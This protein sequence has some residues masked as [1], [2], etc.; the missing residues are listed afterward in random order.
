LNEGEFPLTPRPDPLL[1]DR[2]RA[3]LGSA[4]S[5]L[6]HDTT[7][8]LLDERFLG[9]VALT[10]ASQTLVL[11]RSLADGKGRRREPSSLW[12]AIDQ[13]IPDLPPT[14]LLPEG[15]RRPEHIATYSQLITNLLRRAVR[16]AAESADDATNRRLYD[17][18]ARAGG[19]DDARAR[20]LK[21]LAQS[22][23]RSLAYTNEATLPADV[24]ARLFAPPLE[25]TA[26]Q[27]EDF[28]ACP[29]KHFASRGLRLVDRANDDVTGADLSVACHEI[30]SQ[31][32]RELLKSRADWTNLQSSIDQGSFD[33]IVAAVGEDI[34]GQ[35]LLSS[36][37]NRYLLQRVRQTVSQVL[38]T[39]EAVAQ[40]A[41]FRTS[42]T[43]VRF[44]SGQAMPALQLNSP[45]GNQA[46]LRGKIDRIDS[47]ADRGAF[48]VLDY[49][50]TGS[51]LALDAVH[52]G[53]TIELL[54]QAAVVRRSGAFPPDSRPAGAFYT[55][56]LRKIEDISHPSEA[57]DPS[58]PQ[59]AL[60]TK[61][62]GL[63]DST[64]L[65]Q[66]DVQL[67]QGWSSV[68]SA[69]IKQ[70][71][72]LGFPGKSD[73]LDPGQFEAILGWVERRAGE[74]VDQIVAGDIS[75]SPYRLNQVSPCVRC[76]F[77]SVCRF[78]SSV[79]RYRHLSQVDRGAWLGAIGQPAAPVDLEVKTRSVRKKGTDNAR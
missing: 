8:M 51:T 1:P 41:E 34:R 71:G 6:A 61:A 65:P 66:Y 55:P 78:E 18:V 62:R 63:F 69:F 13:L 79:N 46:T 37:R 40:R 73:A 54:L 30:L 59:F 75:V 56:L 10:R 19:A 45:R 70:D 53:L 25:L 21:Q 9:Y 35:L 23:W 26:R 64:F 22:A 38:S 44:G 2:D 57:P 39:Q 17:W 31:L 58:S 36:S 74:L 15:S 49:R 20:S 14:M 50:L 32:V 7:R 12:R 52:H 33:R 11:T 60:R 77:Q 3:L 68:V 67:A 47:L 42:H 27:L 28:A 24:V 29:F 4:A 72:T 43:D 48:A 76:S 16:P 5:E